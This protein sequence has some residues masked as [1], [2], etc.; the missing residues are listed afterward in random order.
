MTILLHFRFF[1]LIVLPLLWTVFVLKLPL[2][3]KCILDAKYF[4]C[5][6]WVTSAAAAFLKV[7]HGLLLLFFIPLIQEISPRQSEMNSMANYHRLENNFLGVRKRVWFS[8]EPEH[9]KVCDQSARAVWSSVLWGQT[10]LGWIATLNFPH[11]WV[12]VFYLVTMLLTF[13]ICKVQVMTF[14]NKKWDAYINN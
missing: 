12:F 11:L 7:I 5:K 2:K 9:Q 13:L 3:L 4:P 1:I 14:L 8:P 10:V 6:N